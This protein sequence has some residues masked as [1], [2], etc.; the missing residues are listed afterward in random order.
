MQAFTAFTLEELP[1]SHSVHHGFLDAPLGP[2]P[3][4]RLLSA[5]STEG[6]TE[7][8]A[9]DEDSQWLHFKTI[10]TGAG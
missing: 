3:N 10:H 9:A 5:T 2:S 1:G 8:A 6:T 7:A 4:W